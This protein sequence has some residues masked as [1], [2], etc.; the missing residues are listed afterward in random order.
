LLPTGVI[1]S[2]ALCIV[3]KKNAGILKT[4]KYLNYS[5]R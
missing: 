3:K 2:C 1:V 5:Q 4:K